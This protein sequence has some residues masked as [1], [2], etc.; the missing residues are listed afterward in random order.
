MRSAC[1]PTG[2]ANVEMTS[3][4]SSLIL[5]RF[6]IGY[7]NVN[8]KIYDQDLGTDPFLNRVH[9]VN[10]A[11][12]IYVRPREVRKF[13]KFTYKWREGI[14]NACKNLSLRKLLRKPPHP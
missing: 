14:K 10:S 3:E 5:G 13:A 2:D 12:K 1:L 4:V 6:L 7:V 8:F 11:Q 9:N